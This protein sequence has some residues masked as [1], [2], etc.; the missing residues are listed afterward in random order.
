M[1]YFGLVCNLLIYRKLCYVPKTIVGCG[2]MINQAKA[3]GL[4]V[5]IQ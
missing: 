4:E 2:M 5:L 3:V 1:L